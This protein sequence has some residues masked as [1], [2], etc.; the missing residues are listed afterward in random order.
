MESILDSIKLQLGITADYHQF[1]AQIMA[2]IN[3]VFMLL[4]QL[5]VGPKDCFYIEDEFT[6]WDDFLEGRTD[7]NAVKTYMYLRVKLMFDPPSTSFVLDSM[8]RQAEEMEW[9]LNVQAESTEEGDA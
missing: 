3:S 8:K 4:N 2:H 5:G 7:L 6:T 9:R 1:D